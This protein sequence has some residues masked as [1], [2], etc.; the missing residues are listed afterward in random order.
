MALGSPE[1]GKGRSGTYFLPWRFLPSVE[2]A[3]GYVE[4]MTSSADP[5]IPGNGSQLPS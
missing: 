3:A 1:V 4:G 2:T 5:N